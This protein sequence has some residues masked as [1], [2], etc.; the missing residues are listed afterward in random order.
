IIVARAGALT[1]SELCIIGKPVI[2]IPYPH[3][4]E[5]HQT[6]NAQAIV[7]KNAALM[8]PDKDAREHLAPGIIALAQNEQQQQTLATNLKALAIKDADTRIANLIIKFA[9]A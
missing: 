8:I 6:S 3:A 9:N 4:S 1:I 7:N 2:F 5:D